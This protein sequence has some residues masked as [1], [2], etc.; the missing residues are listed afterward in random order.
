MKKLVLGAALLAPFAA[1]ADEAVRLDPVVVTATG[2]PVPASKTLASVIV[3]DREEIQQ[4]QAGD[5]LELLQFYAGLDIDRA[6][7]PGQFGQV[8]IRGAEADQVLLLVDGV[9]MTPAANGA[10]LQ[11][12]A[13][14]LIERIEVVKGPRSTLYGS[15]AQGGVI[16]IFTRQAEKTGFEGRVGLGTDDTRSASAALNYAAAKEHLSLNVEKTSSEGFPPCAGDVIDRGYDRTAVNLRG[17]AQ[18]GQLKVGVRAYDSRGNNAYSSYCGAFNAPVDADFVQQAIALELGLPVTASWQSTL[19][20]SRAAD[21]LEQNQDP[22]FIHSRRPQAD[23]RNVFT[24]GSHTLSVGATAAREEADILFPGF[25]PFPDTRIR[26]ELELYSA[27]VQDS[28]DLGRHHGVFG[29]AHGDHDSYGSETTWNAEYGFDL[30]A[31]T[32]LIVSAGTG[33][34]IPNATERFA[35]FGG[36]PDLR[37]EES[38]NVELGLRQR[39]GKSQRIDLR[40]F[41]TD[42]DDQIVFSGGQNNNVSESSNQGLDLSYNWHTAVWSAT[43]SGLLQDPVNEDTDRQLA[44]RAKRSAAAKLQR[45]FGPHSLGLGVTSSSERPDTNFGTFPATPVKLPG[46]GLLNLYGTLGLGEGWSL[47]SKLEN[48]LDKE[49]QTAFGYNQQGAAFFVSLRYAP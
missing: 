21:K 26:D 3:I 18:I 35:G 20:L 33:F 12:L 39:I 9:R 44:R 36:N 7:G 5:V 27:H 38:R 34:R 8:R 49:Y 32:Q 16:Q 17:D 2:T 28:F 29:V 23:W 1:M 41:R 24:L 48:V 37:P 13:P 45:R 6:G 31:S 25:P 47:E 4:A 10:V 30:F 43:V 15:E 46:Y 11:N 40:A 19:T 22:G 14:E 42:T